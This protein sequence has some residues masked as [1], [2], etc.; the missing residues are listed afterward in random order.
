MPVQKYDGLHI[1]ISSA[2]SVALTI[3][4][5]D[6]QCLITLLGFYAMIILTANVNY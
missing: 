6:N 4:G 5:R 1:R 2:S 3:I